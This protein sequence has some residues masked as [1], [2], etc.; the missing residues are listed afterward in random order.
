[1]VAR[2]FLTVLVSVDDSLKYINSKLSKSYTQAITEHFR[3]VPLQSAVQINVTL[4]Y[5][6]SSLVMLI[7]SYFKKLTT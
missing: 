2:W 5:F 3:D 6:N 1:V 4:L 7:N